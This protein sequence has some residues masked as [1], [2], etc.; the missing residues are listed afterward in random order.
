LTKPVFKG[1]KEDPY[2]K[3]TLKNEE[4]LMTTFGKMMFRAFMIILIFCVIGCDEK[5]DT[6]NDESVSTLTT[7]TTDLENRAT[8]VEART[9]DVE[10]RSTDLETRVTDVEVRTTA[11]EGD[12]SALQTEMD[13]KMNSSGGTMTGNLTVPG[14]VYSTPRTHTACKIGRAHV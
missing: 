7:R 10:G 5:S 12:V 6:H 1:E 9:T 4:V 11:V 14:I 8:A 2:I 3:N 13:G